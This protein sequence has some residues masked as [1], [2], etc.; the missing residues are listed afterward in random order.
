MKVSRVGSGT[1]HDVSRWPLAILLVLV[2]VSAC[3]G[4]GTASA[5][6]PAPTLLSATGTNELHPRQTAAVSSTII[7]MTEGVVDPL[8]SI[9]DAEIF[10]APSDSD[11]AKLQTL[12]AV[13]VTNQGTGSV[14]LQIDAVISSSFPIS[15]EGYVRD[16]RPGETRAAILYVA[17]GVPKA[18]DSVQVRIV[19]E[20]R[21]S[22]LS[23]T[24]KRAVNI[25]L[26]NFTYHTGTGLLFQ[27]R[28]DAKN[29]DSASMAVAVGAVFTRSG[30][31]VGFAR[32][33]VSDLGPGRTLTV[34]LQ[35][36]GEPL[37]T[38]SLV[39]YLDNVV[40]G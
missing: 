16:L 39:C 21:L 15:A 36:I 35:V 9:G 25:R 11:P 26:A 10:R 13:L 29:S 1:A 4:S 30:R 31:V 22:V 27:G 2:F 38:D 32:G 14:S 20:D 28:V 24:A 3:Q 7:P 33:S 18:S 8:L 23:E 5:G 40:I 6:S 17:L 34:P 12:V 37:E 19:S